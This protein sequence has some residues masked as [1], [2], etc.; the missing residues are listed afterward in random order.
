MPDKDLIRIVI[1]NVE[2]KPNLRIQGGERIHPICEALIAL[3]RQQF[4]DPELVKFITSEQDLRK[5]LAADAI[6][7][8]VP[9]NKR[10]ELKHKLMSNPTF[11]ELVN[12]AALYIAENK[13]IQ[14]GLV[15]RQASDETYKD[16][17]F[18]RA[19]RKASPTKVYVE[20]SE[21]QNVHEKARKMKKRGRCLGIV[22]TVGLLALGISGYLYR[23]KIVNYT[24]YASKFRTEISSLQET[25]EEKSSQQQTILSE[26]SVLEKRMQGN[27]QE[28]VNLEKRNAELGDAYKTKEQEVLGLE[29]E[30]N[31]K[32]AEFA[33][34]TKKETRTKSINS[35]LE[36]KVTR[37]TKELA[38]LE[39]QIKEKSAYLGE[40][41]SYLVNLE[42]LKG[43][44][45][46]VKRNIGGLED[47]DLKK[48]RMDYFNRK[49]QQIT[50]LIQQNKLKE[51]SK[52]SAELKKEIQDAGKD[53]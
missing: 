7:D 31:E 25:I 52:L 20:R 5:V 43:T 27:E 3:L 9:E 14:D 18:M 40:L 36:Q 15:L 53:K 50:E 6:I 37:K 49:Y 39:E 38:N 16:K 46:E 44:Y 28:I 24:N 34:L 47:S 45:A 1:K 41:K 35:D 23:T 32:R 11:D 21:I 48:E 4:S 19:L 30:L 8:Y 13:R 17:Y 26:I 12:M 51:A 42:E 29:E 22:T 33:T 10:S 2:K